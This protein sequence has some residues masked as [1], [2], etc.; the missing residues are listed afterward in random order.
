MGFYVPKP[1]S[2]YEARRSGGFQNNLAHLE[3]FNMHLNLSKR[4]FSYFAPIVIWLP[5]P[6]LYKNNSWL[7]ITN[8]KQTNKIQAENSFVRMPEVLASIY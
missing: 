5:W 2:N 1:Q 3:F 8:K 6:R 4:V 7:I